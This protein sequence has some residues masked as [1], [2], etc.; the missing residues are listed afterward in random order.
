[1]SRLLEDVQRLQNSLSQLREN[2][3]KQV[4]ALEEELKSK[5]VLVDELE[6][7]LSKQQDYEEIKKELE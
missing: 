3:N 7:R 2:A 4:T 5:R 1:M 6:E